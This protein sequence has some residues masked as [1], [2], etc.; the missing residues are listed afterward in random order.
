MSRKQFLRLSLTAFLLCTAMVTG[1]CVTNM[2][3]P[4]AAETGNLSRTQAEKLL[5]AAIQSDKSCTRM[6][7]LTAEKISVTCKEAK[8]GSQARVLRFK[9]SPILTGLQ[10]K[11][12]SCVTKKPSPNG[13]YCIYFWHEP[14]SPY[15]YPYARDFARAWYVLANT[16]ANDSEQEA[17]FESA[18][19]G[20]RSASVKPQ[21]PED[22]VRY[23]VKAESA[24]R[25][26]HFDEAVDLYEQVLAIAP[27]WPQGHYNRG[28]ILG[29]IGDYTEAVVELKRYLKLEPE[30]PNARA[31]QLKIYEWDDSGK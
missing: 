9:D 29:E 2:Y 4:T 10:K 30:A 19:Q 1:G 7:R 8:A 14:G 24:V 6:V 16:S 12:W 3:T 13:E 11:G 5:V 23:K 17:A 31:V 18:A 20:Y 26:K 25:Q 27:W 22:A 21:L 28:L 15:G